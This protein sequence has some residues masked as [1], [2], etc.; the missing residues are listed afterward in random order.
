MHLYLVILKQDYEE[1]Q[2]SNVVAK[3][4]EEIK[5]RVIDSFIESGQTPEKAKETLEENV[6]L[7]IQ[8][9]DEVEGYTV[10]LEKKE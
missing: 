3:D 6:T 4:E 1:D 5:Q 7:E 9:S 8:L 2:I 10:I